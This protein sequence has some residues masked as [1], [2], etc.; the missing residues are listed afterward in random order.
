MGS[1]V[2]SRGRAEGV[3]LRVEG[4]FRR[5]TLVSGRSTPLGFKKP[6]AW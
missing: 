3:E 1:S 6:G 4:V 2:E 5:W